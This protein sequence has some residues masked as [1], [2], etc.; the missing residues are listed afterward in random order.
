MQFSISTHFSSIW[1][2]NKTLSGASTP[3]HSGSGSEG[4]KEY[5]AFPQTPVL[6][7]PHHQIV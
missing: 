2:I 6:L 4:K 1:P 7:E 5:F 3:G